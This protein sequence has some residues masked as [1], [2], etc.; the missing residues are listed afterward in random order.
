MSRCL[1]ALTVVAALAACDSDDAS[2]PEDTVSAMDTADVTTNTDV[3]TGADADA[4]AT[5]AADADLVGPADADT[6]L[7]TGPPIP[8]LTPDGC[9]SAAYLRPESVT[10]IAWDS[11][12]PVS[13]VASQDWSITS[14]GTT[15]P[16]AA[17]PACTV[18]HKIPGQ[19]RD[20]AR[21]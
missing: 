21:A 8:T 6:T 15:Y 19:A 1:I 2:T 17:G 11:G 12:V 3:A 20:G 13:D 7:D 4:D 9:G 14:N 10:E 5:T 16:L 18:G